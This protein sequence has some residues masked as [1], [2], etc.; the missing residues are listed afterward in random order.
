MKFLII[1]LFSFLGQLAFAHNITFR[2]YTTNCYG[3][4]NSPNAT[5]KYYL[6]NTQTTITTYRLVAN[7]PCL[8]ASFPCHDHEKPTYSVTNNT[9]CTCRAPNLVAP[10]S[11]LNSLDY[12]WMQKLKSLLYLL[13]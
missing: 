7:F 13:R 1:V 6:R 12:P 11:N 10:V 5:T 4:C 2:S 3:Q 8:S 9:S